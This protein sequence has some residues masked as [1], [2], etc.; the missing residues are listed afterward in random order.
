MLPGFTA[1]SSLRQRNGTAE[2]RRG[3]DAAPVNPATV[4]S[5]AKK[6]GTRVVSALRTETGPAGPIPGSCPVCAAKCL[7]S[8]KQ[9]S[10]AFETCFATC[11]AQY[12]PSGEWFNPTPSPGVCQCSS[13]LGIGC[14]VSVNNCTQGFVPSCNCGLFSNECGCVQA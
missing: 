3:N 12:C 5:S 10:A 9:G 8:G 14:S 4:S 13:F 2:R 11:S 7:S 1:G 6:G